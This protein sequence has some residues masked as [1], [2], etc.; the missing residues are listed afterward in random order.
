MMANG[1]WFVEEAPLVRMRPELCVVSWA[2]INHTQ[3]IVML[4]QGE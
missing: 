2:T 3:N 1:E 4:T